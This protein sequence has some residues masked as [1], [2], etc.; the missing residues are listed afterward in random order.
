LGTLWLISA[1]WLNNGCLAGLAFGRVSGLGAKW[2]IYIYIY[3][4]EKVFMVEVPVGPPALA[5]SF[6]SK[7]KCM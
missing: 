4:G 2:G 3:C 7:F 1:A 6:E 5:I